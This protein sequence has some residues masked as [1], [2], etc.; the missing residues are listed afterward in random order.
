M[1]LNEAVLIKLPEGNPTKHATL[2]AQVCDQSQ[3]HLW[4]T[5]LLVSTMQTQSSDNE[6]TEKKLKR[7]ITPV[8]ILILKYCSAAF[9][10]ITNITTE[11]AHESLLYIPQAQET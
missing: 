8:T 9:L 10:S 4:R 2:A 3:Q 7:H 5:S 1:P 11:L 6:A